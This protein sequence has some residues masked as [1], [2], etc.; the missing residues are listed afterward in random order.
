MIVT[1]KVAL[2]IAALVLLF[3]LLQTA[4]FSLVEVVHVSFWILPA[5]AAIFGLLGGSMVGATV[6]FS[7]G[8][9]SDGL[10]D[11]PLGTAC[12]VFMGIGY[13][14]GLYR[15]RG[16]HPTRLE[17]AG[18]CA[19]ATFAAN[20]ALGLFT[21]LLGFD[22]L[23][24]KDLLVDV[25]IQALYG[26]LLAFPIYALITRVLRPALIDERGGRRRRSPTALET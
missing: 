1:T 3:S 26:F 7:I 2:R 21:V 19:L 11:G 12:L 15:E 9:L 5:C 23:L 24:S 13:A 20:V 6:G 8:F 10:A 14:A 25:V 4:F 18:I 16:A 22:A 17:M